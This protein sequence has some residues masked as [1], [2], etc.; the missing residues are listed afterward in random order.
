MGRAGTEAAEFV[1]NRDLGNTVASARV[2]LAMFSSQISVS[3][4]QDFLKT[5]VRTYFTIAFQE[6][7]SDD[8]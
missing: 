3:K 1:R 2:I 7:I 8:T 6:A 4:L 5:A